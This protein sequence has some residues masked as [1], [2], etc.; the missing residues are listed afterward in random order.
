MHTT[1]IRANAEAA[2][3]RREAN[4]AQAKGSKLALEMAS[5]TQEMIQSLQ[6]GLKFKPQRYKA[7]EA[8]IWVGVAVSTVMVVGLLCYTIW[9]WGA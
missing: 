5:E 3:A 1:L 2:E 8:L 9:N 6:N 4:E 7:A